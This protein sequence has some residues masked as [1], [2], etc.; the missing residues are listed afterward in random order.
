MSEYNILSNAG[1]VISSG[2]NIIISSLPVYLKLQIK[3]IIP[4]AQDIS[5]K[6]LFNN[7]PIL[8]TRE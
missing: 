8:E 7:K 3:K 6:V 1:E 4:S 2:S 5:I